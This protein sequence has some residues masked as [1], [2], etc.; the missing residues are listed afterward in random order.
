MKIP[1]NVF[2]LLLIFTA[3][4]FAVDVID[5]DVKRKPQDDSWESYKTT[6]VGNT[7]EDAWKTPG[8]TNRFGGTVAQ[9]FPE[10]G[11]FHIR[12]KNDVWLI[13]DPA[14]GLFVSKGI[15]S[16][17]MSSTQTSRVA[18]VSQFGG[19]QNLSLIHI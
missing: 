12:K 10:T 6:V 9:L 4:A 11:F 19:P 17:K 2:C 7:P 8:E 18:V 15:N 16:V 13:V 1:L 5:V 14:G 3:T